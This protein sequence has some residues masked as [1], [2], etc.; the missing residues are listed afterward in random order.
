MRMTL[1]YLVFGCLPMFAETSATS[2]VMKSAGE[3]VTLEIAAKSQPTRAPIALHWEVI[4]PAQLM[5][6]DGDAE[7]GSA[8]LTS[9]KSLQCHAV[10]PHSYGCVLSGGENPIADGQIAIFHFR[11]RTTAGPGTTTVRIE[12]V[13]TG[14][15]DSKVLSLDDTEAVITIR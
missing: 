8:A 15:L 13:V 1:V 14:T 12:R 11:I 7:I 6:M 4:F 3:R 5:E 9:G 2:S 10:N